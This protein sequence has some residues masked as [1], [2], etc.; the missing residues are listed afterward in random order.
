V[1]GV[2]MRRQAGAQKEGMLTVFGAQG[3]DR[4]IEVGDC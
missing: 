3:I 2:A 4:L 1:L